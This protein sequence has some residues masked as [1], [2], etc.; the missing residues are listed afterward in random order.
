MMI[1]FQA[2]LWI[3]N[4]F[5]RIRNHLFSVVRIRVRLF[6]LLG[7]HGVLLFTVMRIRIQDPA[8]RQSDESATTGIQ[9]RLHL[10]LHASIVIRIRDSAHRR[11][12]HWHTD[13]APFES[14]CR[15]H[16]DPDPASQNN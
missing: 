9:T 16:C 15:L 2:V 11:S 10:S 8:H 7:I 1:A 14:P 6:T 13:T 3:S 12:D 5:M 4:T